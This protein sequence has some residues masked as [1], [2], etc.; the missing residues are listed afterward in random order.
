MFFV[1]LYLVFCLLIFF[2]Q[3]LFVF[4]ACCTIY[5]ESEWRWRHHRPEPLLLL[6]LLTSYYTCALLCT[7]LS[8]TV[9]NIHV[10]YKS[11]W[12]HITHAFVWFC[13][14]AYFLLSICSFVSHICV[15]IRIFSHLGNC[16]IFYFS[17]IQYNVQHW[18]YRRPSIITGRKLQ[19][20]SWEYPVSQHNKSQGIAILLVSF[21]DTNIL[22]HNIT[23]GYK[24]KEYPSSVL[25]QA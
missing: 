19:F 3:S 21:S 10:Q 11:F 23:K 15:D 20:A 22:C 25:H 6:T 9:H 8:Y 4:C 13:S 18:C 12:P 2:C 24:T 17:V 1:F 16:A 14:L 5:L 7:I